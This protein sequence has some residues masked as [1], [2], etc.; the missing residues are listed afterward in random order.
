[1]NTNIKTSYPKFILAICISVFCTNQLKA[2]ISI[3]V[4][5]GIVFT[6]LNHARIPGDNGTFISFSGELE[7][8]PKI[9]GRVRAAYRFSPRSE[10]L[11]LFAPLQNTYNGSVAR[12]VFFQGV[13]YP[14]G[15]HLNATY[16]FNSYRASYRYY[17]LDREKLEIGVGLTLKIRDA[18]IGLEGGELQ[19]EKTDFGFVPLINFVVNWQATDRFGL[20]LDGDAL[21][22]PQGRAEDV[23]AAVTY[24]LSENFSMKAGYRILEGGAGNKKVYTFSLFHYGVL[25]AILSL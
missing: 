12:D 1:M 6:G 15:T 11:L 13:N 18:L 25:G 4:E 5:T 16:K 24:K 3:D 9:F 7:S 19:S 10:I 23:L 20:L 21:A 14:A 2:Q 22:A 17:V 8:D